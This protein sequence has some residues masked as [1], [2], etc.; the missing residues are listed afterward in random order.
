MKT[1]NDY[2]NYVKSIDPKGKETLEEIENISSIISTII[3]QRKSLGMSQRDLASIC[4]IPQSS[5]ARIESL[6]TT[7]N[8]NTLVKI[9]QSLNLKITVSPISA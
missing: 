3:Q 9:L 1:W 5:I 7:P 2:K 4:G 6:K 8:L